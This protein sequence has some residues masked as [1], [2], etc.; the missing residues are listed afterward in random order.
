[1]TR[2]NPSLTVA[3]RTRGG[4]QAAVL[5]RKHP[6]RAENPNE[7]EPHRAER[8]RRPATD[9]MPVATNEPSRARPPRRTRPRND[10]NEPKPCVEPK[11]T[12]AECRTPG[13]GRPAAATDSQGP[14]DHANGRLTCKWLM[15]RYRRPKIGRIRNGA[16][17]MSQGPA[18]DPNEPEPHCCRTNPRRPPG[19]CPAHE[20]TRI[21]LRIQTN[22]SLTAPN[23]AGPPVNPNEPSLMRPAR[24]SPSGVV[25]ARARIPTVP[26]TTRT[27]G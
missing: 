7:P 14:M 21:G 5:R 8:M 13:A 6:N 9:L 2:T 11:R 20:S 25:A 10:P 27:E 24:C 15:S 3:E 17:R 4:R 16:S 18:H 12:R 19:F 26:W 23:E 1:M 22:P